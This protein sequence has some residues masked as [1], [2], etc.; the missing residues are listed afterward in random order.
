MKLHGCVQTPIGMRMKIT[1]LAGFSG[2]MLLVS[3][4]FVS[5][6]S[7]SLSDPLTIVV[8][9]SRGAETADETLAPV[10]T[11]TRE[12]IERTGAIS[13]PEVLA[14]VPGVQISNNGGPGQVTSLFLRG[15]ESDST[16]VLIDGVKVGSAT[17]GT[18]PFQ[19]LPVNQ[20]EKIEVVRGPRSSLYG[21]EAIGGVI[22][23]FTRRGGVGTKPIFSVTG[24]SHNTSDINLG[25][26][27]GDSKRWYSLSA[28][29]SRTDGF[30][31]LPRKF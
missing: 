28:T 2:L 7:D 30:K 1:L 27:G 31:R 18:T 9:A 4:P 3:S 29:S 12:Q 14:T 19:D 15:T 6:Q 16:L 5:A 23:I 17:L 20:I 21:S 22:Q 10:T 25:V 11:I 24:G 13:V 26:S 8:T